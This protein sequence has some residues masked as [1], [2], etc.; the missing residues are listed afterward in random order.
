VACE[1]RDQSILEQ[2][3][4]AKLDQVQKEYGPGSINFKDKLL[5]INQKVLATGQV[6]QAPPVMPNFQRGLRP[7]APTFDDDITDVLQGTRGGK[8]SDQEHDSR[9]L[10]TPPGMASSSSGTQEL[11]D[12]YNRVIQGLGKGLSDDGESEKG[13]GLGKR[14]HEGGKGEDTKG[15]KGRFD[16]P[17]TQAGQAAIDLDPKLEAGR[18]WKPLCYSRGLH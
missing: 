18:N 4:Q 15:K 8:W 6:P 16:N 17:V 13:K 1:G 12:W 10:T 14:S 5:K 11:P 2:L 7:P 9:F 3:L